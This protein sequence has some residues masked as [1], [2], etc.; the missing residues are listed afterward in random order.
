M[1]HIVEFYEN[2]LSKEIIKYLIYF[3]KNP[4]DYDAIL[5]NI[6]ESKK[7]EWNETIHFLHDDIEIEELDI[8]SDKLKEK[9]LSKIDTLQFKYQ[10]YKQE[11]YNRIKKEYIDEVKKFYSE[12]QVIMIIPSDIPKSQLF[13]EQSIKYQATIL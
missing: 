13:N 6:S 8:L 5:N 9:I 7:N 10:K 4:E 1:N 11:E 2:K 3:L 12:Y